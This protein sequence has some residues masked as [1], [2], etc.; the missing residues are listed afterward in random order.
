ML[1]DQDSDVRPRKRITR[2]SR[3]THQLDGAEDE[4]DYEVPEVM[5]DT[6]EDV[7]PVRP[8][9]RPRTLPKDPTPI[10]MAIEDDGDNEEGDEEV[11]QVERTGILA[12]SAAMDKLIRKSLFVTAPKKT[13][14][15]GVSSVTQR[16]SGAAATSGSGTTTMAAVFTALPAAS[17]LAVALHA[18]AS[19]AVSAAMPIPPPIMRR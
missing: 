9:G 19:S 3:P 6:E 18:A 8:R 10:H 1:E 4:D 16:I 7:A 13:Y 12:T 5:D 11:V 17:L 15:F 2:G 14:D